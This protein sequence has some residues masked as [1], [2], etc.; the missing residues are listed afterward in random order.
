MLC[1]AAQVGGSWVGGMPM[2]GGIVGKGAGRGR[3]NGDLGSA[4]HLQGVV[5]ASSRVTAHVCK[6]V[7][8]LRAG[9][10]R[11][12]WSCGCAAMRT[13]RERWMQAEMRRCTQQVQPGERRG[14]T[15]V[16]AWCGEVWELGKRE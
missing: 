1:T 12:L 15:P 8:T 16:G 6:C 11:T 9:R 3:P 10:W 13:E 7:R 14:R 4:L 2:W 5:F